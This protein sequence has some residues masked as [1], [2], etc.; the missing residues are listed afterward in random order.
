MNRES[1]FKGV[2][3]VSP[4]ES[5]EDLVKEFTLSG[6]KVPSDDGS[7]AIQYI[8]C[9][10]VNGCAGLTDADDGVDIVLWCPAEGPSVKSE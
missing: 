1:A 10:L 5:Q 7:T 9:K 2:L 8:F 3:E 6:A 4:S